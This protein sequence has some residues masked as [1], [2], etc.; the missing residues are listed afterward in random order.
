L[1][2]TA[3]GAYRR[4]VPSPPWLHAWVRVHL[5]IRVMRE[6]LWGDDWAIVKAELGKALKLRERLRRAA[7]WN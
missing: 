4:Y 2:I 6:T 1:S 7:W 5:A 3:I